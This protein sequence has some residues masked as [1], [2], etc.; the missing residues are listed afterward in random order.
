MTEDLADPL[1]RAIRAP[2]VSWALF[3][4]GSTGEFNLSSYGWVAEDDDGEELGNG[5][6]EGSWTVFRGAGP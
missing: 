2:T 4:Q 6:D 3:L 1:C 5:V